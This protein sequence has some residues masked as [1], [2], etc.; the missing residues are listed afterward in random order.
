MK[1]NVFGRHFKRDVNE[2]KALFKNLLTSLVLHERIKT[3]VPKA[4]A[5][6]AAADKLITKAKLGG[7]HGRRMI[8]G[9]V[10][11]EAMV[12]LMSDLGP[13]FANR[14]GGYTR[15][16]KVAKP[17]V[18]D[19]ADMAIIEW[20]DRP[21]VVAKTD[22][23][24]KNS[25]KEATDVLEAEVVTEKKAKPAAKKVEKKETKKAEAKKPTKAKKEDK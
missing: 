10:N 6:K 13:R 18:A 8:E 23:K 15:I 19:N 5:I 2:R 9:T 17:R 11:Q 25:K 3:T 21:V 20:T 4:K 24:V 16:I 22:T 1:K 12:K 7:D 14:V